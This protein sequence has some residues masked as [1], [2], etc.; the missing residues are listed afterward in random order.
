[1]SCAFEASCLVPSLPHVDVGRGLGGWI[2]PKRRHYMRV[3][4]LTVSYI[5]WPFFLCSILHYRFLRLCR[6]PRSAPFFD[7]TA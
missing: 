6:F 2:H 5:N 3:E 7:W 4:I 1:M